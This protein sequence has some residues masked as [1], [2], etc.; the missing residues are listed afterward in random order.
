MARVLDAAA[1]ALPTIWAGATGRPIVLRALA[2]SDDILF[3]DFVREL[4]PASRRDRFHAGVPELPA[5]WLRVLLRVDPAREFALIALAS[6]GGRAVCIAEARY[7][8]DPERDDTREFALVVADRW[9]G[10]GLGAELLR[11]LVAHAR[12]RG[13]RHLFGDVLHGNAAMVR[14]AKRA[15]FRTARH[16]DDARLVRVAQQLAP[17]RTPEATSDLIVAPAAA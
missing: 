6:E 11:R 13:V 9:H 12:A 15:G 3:G 1:D 16:P 5:P 10:Q 4:S 17:D 14:L 2:P 7:A 8:V